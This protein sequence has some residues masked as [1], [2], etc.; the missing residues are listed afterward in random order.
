MK[1][2]PRV[3]FVALCLALGS[4]ATPEPKPD[5][6]VGWF[7]DY[8]NCR[9][10]YA[11]V[12]ARVAA[13]GVT[14]AGYYRVP[15]YPYF[16]TD[17]VLASFSREVKT[18][19]EIGGWMRRMRELDQEAREF[20][21]RNLG[22]N[23]QE[24]AIQR[25]RFLNCGRTLASID[26]LDEPEAF[27][28]LLSLVQPEDEYSARQRALGLYP[29]RTA[30]MRARIAEQQ[31]MLDDAYA[32]PLEK[33]ATRAP[34][35]L[36]KPKPEADLSLVPNIYARV[37]PDELGFPGLTDSQWRAL[38]EY[39]AP[40][41]WIETASESDRLVLPTHSVRGVAA[42]LGKPQAHHY[43]TFARFGGKPLAQMN[44]LFWFKGANGSPLDGFIWRVTLDDKAQ[45]L[46]YESM[47]TSGSEHRWYPVQPLVRRERNGDAHGIPVVAPQPAPVR[48]ATLRM[49]SARHDILRVVDA[50]DADAG[51]AQT[52]E[53]RRYDDLL[54][55]P[56]PDGGT[57]SLFG[58]DGLVPGT[59]G[60]E[61]V[62]GLASGIRAPG[63]LRQLG[64]HAIAP[65]GRAHF[66]EPFLLES[67]FV[68]P[69]R[70]VTPPPG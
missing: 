43:V 10:D 1:V 32:Q 51:T 36:W 63:A 41:L 55:L 20:E 24:A 52:Y 7:R 9:E 68:P 28:R 35:S 15:G 42:D 16:R 48:L 39:H 65:V 58:P 22:M 18:L 31:Q 40:Q 26:F 46:V 38:A 66:D 45:P 13:A 12:D 6:F 61:P 62:G 3:I 37:L 11:A 5:P 19:E 21:Y 67:V 59:H 29:F 70:A 25:D 30:G 50:S 47:H 14:E 54:A 23:L 27:A 2:R 33:I 49:S 56:R 64:R 8:R 34:L 69:A 57:R 17:R 53:I 44:Y 4:C 60:A